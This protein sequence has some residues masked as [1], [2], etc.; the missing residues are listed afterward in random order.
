MNPECCHAVGSVAY[1][2]IRLPSSRLGAFANPVAAEQLVRASWHILMF[3]M[4]WAV[5]HISTFQPPGLSF[6]QLSARMKHHSTNPRIL[7]YSYSQQNQLDHIKH[8]CHIT[9][10]TNRIKQ[11]Q[12]MVQWADTHIL[13]KHLPMYLEQGYKMARLN[14]CPVLRQCAGRTARHAV[15]K[16]TWEPIRE[17]A[18]N[19]PKEVME[20]F[21][22]RKAGIKPL[23]L[24]QN[25]CA[26]PDQS[27]I[28][29]N[30]AF[31][32]PYMTEKRLPSYMNQA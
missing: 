11:K 16:A 31:R 8:E 24:A 1:R 12:C 5:H 26:R 32:C 29:T 7:E 30:K 6:E 18:Q 23:K 17:P 22:A 4:Y 2:R 25:N 10:K 27:Q 20:D 3:C 19:V 15:V 14:T 28:W 21:E 13:K 9:D